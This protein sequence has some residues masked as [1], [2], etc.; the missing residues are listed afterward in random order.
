MRSPIFW[1]LLVGLG[2][3]AIVLIARHDAGTVGPLTTDDFASLALKIALLVFLG[4]SAL[5]V[6]RESIGKAS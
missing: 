5:V 1:L 4:S 6:F 3:A 2:L